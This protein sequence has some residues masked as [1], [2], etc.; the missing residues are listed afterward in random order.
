MNLIK[1]FLIFL[2]FSFT[3]VHSDNTED[4]KNGKKF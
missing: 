1:Y 4:L 2:F 3:P